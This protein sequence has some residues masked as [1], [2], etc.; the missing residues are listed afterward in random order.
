[1]KRFTSPNDWQS[2]IV[3]HLLSVVQPN[4]GYLQQMRSMLV[5]VEGEALQFEIMI[6][7]VRHED[8]GSHW[9]ALGE[10]ADDDGYMVEVALHAKGGVLELF[11]R[12]KIGPELIEPEPSIS[13]VRVWAHEGESRRG[14]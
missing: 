5:H 4:D 14:T 1:M 3:G 11:E 13:R 10:Y 7:G 6:P 9:L 12:Y 8:D 2:A